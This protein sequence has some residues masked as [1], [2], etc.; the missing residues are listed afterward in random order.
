MTTTPPAERDWSRDFDHT[1]PA[2]AERAPEI[3]DELRSVCP[4]AHSN[5][6]GGTWLPTRHEDVAAIA[7]DTEH[8]SS[9]GV[10]VAPMDPPLDLAPAGYAPPITSDPPFHD[11]ARRLLLP[12]FAPK[13]IAALEPTT[14]ELCRRLL[15]E[16]EADATDTID[17]V[18]RYTRHIPVQV[19]AAML[20]VPASDGDRFRVFI[21]R[22]L[23][24]PG[25][26][27]PVE[28]EDT[29]GHYVGAMIAEHREH[30]RDDLIGFL[31]DA[32]IDRE[33]LSDDQYAKRRKLWAG[34]VV[35]GYGL[36]LGGLGAL[37]GGI[38]IRKK[39]T[40]AL[41]SEPAA[42]PG[43]ARQDALRQVNIGTG[44]LIGAAAG[45]TL[46]LVLG[47]FANAKLKSLK[48]RQ[49]ASIGPSLYPG[50]GG[51]AAQV[52]F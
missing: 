14:T 11:Q 46:G 24:R 30:P 20:G 12:A 22:I 18:E 42:A 43:N 19:I 25:Q 1:D 3:W 17:A 8:F 45:A 5:R 31:I 15:D 10:I 28:P 40:D 33:P 2:Y 6:F 34:L 44:L 27:G 39:G 48:S 32:E 35:T 16:I 21:H 38:A 36:A 51:I 50:G 37:Y 47:V 49:G 7:Y 26:A 23:E 13:P 41:S 52:R 4:V 9:C 29:L